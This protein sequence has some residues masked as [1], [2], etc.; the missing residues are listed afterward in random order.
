MTHLLLFSN[1]VSAR[2]SGSTN[3]FPVIA[4]ADSADLQSVVFIEGLF[5]ETATHDRKNSIRSTTGPD[6]GANGLSVSACSTLNLLLTTR[7]QRL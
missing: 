5:S 6:L 1:R 4:V 3:I 2:C 7:H